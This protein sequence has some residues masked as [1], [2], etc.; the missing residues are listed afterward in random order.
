[1]GGAFPHADGPA[2]AAARHPGLRAMGCYLCLPAGLPARGAGA[3]CTRTPRTPLTLRTLQP[4]T[5]LHVCMHQPVHTPRTYHATPSHTDA[6]LRA[7]VV[8]A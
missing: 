3:D 1:M 7:G 5:A 4:H 8:G 2:A 6:C